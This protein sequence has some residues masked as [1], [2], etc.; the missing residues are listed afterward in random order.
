M[1]C[2]FGSSLY[3]I[4]D[5][6]SADCFKNEISPLL[7]ANYRLKFYQD[8]ALVHVR[9]KVNYDANSRIN[10][11][12]KNMDMILWFTCL[13]IQHWFSWK[14]L[15]AESTIVLHL[16]VSIFWQDFPFALPLRK[17]NLYYCLIDDNKTI[18]IHCN[19]G[20]FKSTRFSIK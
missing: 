8:V 5:K 9:K 15:L 11:W 19:K 6:I 20:V 7:K 10:Y 16:L 18:E 12:R 17:D 13:H 3:F 2:L 14:V 4:G 1:F